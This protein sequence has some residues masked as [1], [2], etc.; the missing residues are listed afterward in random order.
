MN[1]AKPLC[2][3]EGPQLSPRHWDVDWARDLLREA[4][5]HSPCRHVTGYARREIVSGTEHEQGEMSLSAVTE[6]RTC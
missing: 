4:L 1:V 2:L 5:L 3:L 6:K